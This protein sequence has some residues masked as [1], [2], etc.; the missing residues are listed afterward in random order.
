MGSSPYTK[1]R[2]E[3][4]ARGARTL[5]EVAERLGLETNGSQRSYLRLQLKRLGVDISHFVREVK[6]T[7][8]ILQA[9]VAKST[10]MNEVLRNLGLNVVG[11]NHTHISRKVAAYGIDISHFRVPPQRGKPRKP[12]SP[13]ALLV[14]QDPD[15]ARRI[16]NIRL[17][18]AMLSADVPEKC[19]DCGNPGEWLGEPLLLEV[20]HINGDWR[21][22]RLGNLRFLC[23]NCH[24]A[25]DTYRGRNRGRAAGGHA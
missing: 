21:D 14:L 24:C 3:E 20:D 6:W 15:K 2:L 11:G 23:P 22:N 19:A 25:T 18:R 5:S 12:S 10:S 13:Q 8:E 7:E 4:A 1:E 9:A 17:R 16:P